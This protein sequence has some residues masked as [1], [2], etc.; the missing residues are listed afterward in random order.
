MGWLSKLKG[1]APIA[2][3]LVP[4]AYAVQ[5]FAR[6]D[7]KGGFGELAFDAITFVPGIGGAARL[8]RVAKVAI[9]ARK[10][11]KGFRVGRKTRKVVR[12]PTRR[13]RATKLKG[14]KRKV[15]GARRGPTVARKAPQ[16]ARATIVRGGRKTATRVKVAKAASPRWAGSRSPVKRLK[17]L[18]EMLRARK[19]AVKKVKVKP[20]GRAKAKIQTRKAV[21]TGR[22]STAVRGGIGIAVLGGAA[23]A[24]GGAIATRGGQTPQGAPIIGPTVTTR[25]EDDMARRRRGGSRVAKRGGAKKARGGGILG[26]AK[27]KKAGLP[28]MGM[29]LSAMPPVPGGIGP[30]LAE[31]GFS[32]V[33]G[34][35]MG[36]RVTAVQVRQQYGRRLSNAE[37]QQAYGYYPKVR[38]A[39]RRTTRRRSSSGSSQLS[40]LKS[41]LPLLGH[42]G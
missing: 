28:G 5:A 1:I 33:S 23:I 32:Q 27:A 7:I 30:G 4:G 21:R 6:G 19:L 24:G 39:R 22:V 20:G 25:Q 12:S 17:S 34:P 16:R 3:A 18:K 37:F 15:S 10:G 2:M 40:L 41:I 29:G 38:R 31:G 26:R 14:V 35:G 36:Q 13:V 9:K 8:A 11:F 42:R